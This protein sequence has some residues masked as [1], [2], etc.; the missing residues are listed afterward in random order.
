MLHS[1]AWRQPWAAGPSRRSPRVA[2]L[3]LA[4]LALVLSVSW[5]G[6]VS[7]A[8]AAPTPKCGHTQLSAR[9]VRWTGAAGSRI[10]DVILVN[11]SFVKCTIRDLPQVQLVDR[12]GAALISGPAA[13]TTGPLHTLLP[14]AFLKTAV[15]DSNYCGPAVVAPA[16]VAFKLPAPLGR[17]IAMPRSSGDVSGVP[18][19]NGAPGSAGTISM[20]PWRT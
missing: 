11:T 6:L 14:L 15:S 1:T 18:P 5:S 8:S 7:Q 13:A 20:Q 9:V 16:S 3:A 17:V 12:S 19:C 10:A 4:S 2:L